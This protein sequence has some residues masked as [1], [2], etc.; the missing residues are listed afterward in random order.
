MGNHPIIIENHTI[1]GDNAMYKK[2][3]FML[4]N[5]ITDVLELLEKGNVWE[6]KS[7]LMKAQQDAEEVYISWNGDEE[8]SEEK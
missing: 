5:V 2:M 7:R 4:F 1:K 3:Y 6:A 8:Y